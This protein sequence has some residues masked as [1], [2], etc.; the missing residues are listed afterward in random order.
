MRGR[1]EDVR[2]GEPFIVIAGVAVSGV[3]LLA[4]FV[5][6]LKQMQERPQGSEYEEPSRTEYSDYGEDDED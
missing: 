3:V 4:L 1:S 5:F 2:W 6:S